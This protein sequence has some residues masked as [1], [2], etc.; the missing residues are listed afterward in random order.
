[1]DLSI[2]ILSFRDREKLAATIQSV[3]RSKLSYTFETIVV[4][5]DS[6]DGSAEMVEREFPQV[7]L[8]RNINNGFAAGN[9]VGMRQAKG[10]YILLLN[11]DTEV[12]EDTLEECV[13]L[14][15]QRPDIGMLGCKVLRPDGDYD[16]ASKKALP[17]PLGA[18]FR[19]VGLSKLF[20]NSKFFVRYNVPKSSYEVEGEMGSGTGAFLMTRREVVGKIGMLD[21]DYWMYWEDMDWCYRCVQAGWKV[22]YY[23]KVKII[24]HKGVSSRKTPYRALRAFHAAMWVFYKKHYSRRMPFFINW[25]AYI[26][27]WFRFAVLVVVNFFRKQPYVSK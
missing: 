11:P 17:D 10:K 18:F 14:M 23:P 21:E 4:D 19:Y 26:A 6:G 16:Y 1:M 7:I 27:I 3:Y 12:M 24:H 20:P 13:K 25:L 22:W 9:N 5:N 8:I 2:I 15:E